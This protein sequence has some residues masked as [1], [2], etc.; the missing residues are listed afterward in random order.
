MGLGTISPFSLTTGL[1]L[2]ECIPKIALCGRF[3]IGVPMRLPNTPPLLMVKVPPCISSK[4]SVPSFAFCPKV[5]ILFST[6]AKFISSV[7]RNTGTTK[8]LGLATATLISTNS[9]YTISC[10]SSSIYAFTAGISWRLMVDAL[11]K[12]DMKPS[13]TPCFFAKSSLYLDRRDMR[14]DISTSW[15]VVRRA[16]VFCADLRRSATRFR[17]VDIFVRRSVR[18][19]VIGSTVHEV[20]GGAGVAGGGGGVGAAGA[21]AGGAAAAAGGASGAAAASGTAAASGSGA[22]SAAGA[23]PP[24]GASA[25][26]SIRNKLLPT[27]TTSSISPKIST[28]FPGSVARTSTETLSVSSTTTTSSVLT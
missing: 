1:I 13:F 12:H 24:S 6:S 7:F 17:R 19:P 23:A 5:A 14:E 21:A 18:F 8:P 2:I 25:S 22:V 16:A 9:L 20:V 28:I 26:V 11:I 4:L 3:K 10:A 27:S 15:K